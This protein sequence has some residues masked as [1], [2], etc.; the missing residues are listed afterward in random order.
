M[1]TDPEKRYDIKQV[2]NHSFVTCKRNNKNLDIALKKLKTYK[3]R[4]KLKAS[5]IAIYWMNLVQ[6][7]KR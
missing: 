3:Q 7:K 5:G 2:L 6:K 4:L 1:E